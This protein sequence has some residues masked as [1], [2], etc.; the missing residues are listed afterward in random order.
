M[1]SVS[2]PMD[3]HKN[4]K[5]L[6]SLSPNNL[7]ALRFEWRF[8]MHSSRGRNDQLAIQQII[9]RICFMDRILGNS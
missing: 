9:K 5:N 2:S 8:S 1:A 7:M 4:T 6:L 3:V